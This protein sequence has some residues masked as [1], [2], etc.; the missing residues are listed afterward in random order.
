M[1]KSDSMMMDRVE[2]ST[3]SKAEIIFSYFSPTARFDC[4]NPVARF[5]RY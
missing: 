1:N 2:E 5:I 3:A 4:D